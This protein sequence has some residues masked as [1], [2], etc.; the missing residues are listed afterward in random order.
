MAQSGLQPVPQNRISA[1]ML[2]ILGAI[3]MVGLFLIGFDQGHLFSL[4]Q[5]SEAFDEQFLHEMTHDMRH[6]MGLPCH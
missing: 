4:V 3:F 5:G 6:T 2:A 1:S